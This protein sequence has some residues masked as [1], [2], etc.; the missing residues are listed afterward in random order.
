MILQDLAVVVS[1]SGRLEEAEN[2]ADRS[3]RILEKNYS[4]DALILLRPLHMLSSARVQQ[5]KIAGAS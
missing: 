2:Y 3:V 5:G 1:R 4:P